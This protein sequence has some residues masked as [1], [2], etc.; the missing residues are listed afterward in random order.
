MTLS[1]GT[2]LGPYEVLSTV[3]AGGMGEVYKARDTR[4]ERTVAVKVLPDH[5]SSSP[6]VRQRFEREA[7]TISQLSHPHICALYDVGREGETEYL[8][9]EYLEGETLAERL[10]KGPLPLEQTLRYGVEIADALDKAHRR[11]IVH[12]DLKPGNV[13]LTKS[14]VKLLDFGLAKAVAPLPPQ[15]ELTSMPT[16]SRG[17][18]TQEG[19]ILGTVQYMAPEQ[20]EGQEADARTDIFALGCLLYEA[21]A[22]KRAFEGK[23]QV[24]LIGAILKDQP[25]PISSVQPMSPPALDRVVQACL[26]KDPE[27]RWQTAHDV[28]LQLK[29]VAEG[30]SVAGTPAPVTARR[31]VRERS[32][33]ILA[34]IFLAVALLLA[35]VHFREVP[36]EVRAA[37]FIVSPPDQTTLGTGP[38]APQAALSPDGRYL[39]LAL[40][41]PDAK[42]NLW[43]RPLDSLDVQRLAG[44]EEASLPFWSPD[45]RFI[46]F[47]TDNKLKTISISGGSPQTLA[48][49]SRPGGA[50][51]SRDGLILFAATRTS[52]I[53]RVSASGGIVTDLVT[54]ARHRE[55]AFYAFPQFLPDGRHFLYF[56]LSQK[57]DARGIYVTSLDS[58]ESKQI[59]NADVRAIYAHPGFLLFLRQGTLLAQRFDA[60]R[61]RLTGESVRIAE[62]VAYN[63]INGRN[64]VTVSDTGVLAYRAG[65]GAGIPTTELLW[66]DREGKRVGVAGGRDLYLRPGLSRDGRRIVV[67]RIDLRSD[68]RDLWVIDEARSTSSRLTFG[69]SRHSNAVWSPDGTRIVFASDLG[70]RICEKAAS[71]A[72]PERVLLS[73]DLPKNPTDWSADGRFILYDEIAAKTGTDIWILPLAGDQKPVPLLRTEFFEGQGQLSSDGRW[74]AYVSDESGRKEIYVQPFPFSGAKWQISSEGGSFP[75]WRGDGKELFYLSPDQKVMTVEVE[76]ESTLRAGKPRALFPARYFNIP[77]SP[78]TVSRDGQRFLIS[79]PPGEEGNTAPVTVIL[80]WTAELNKK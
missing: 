47:F 62:E 52:G 44:T 45:S 50:T 18:L 19:T 27:D 65:G 56:V 34:A 77:V 4:L 60:D 29:W 38:A 35:I 54:P 80:N 9:M 6:E 55:E 48:D 63:P 71:G 79:T 75:K 36:P 30:G 25:L 72:G 8:V 68:N 37:R 5:L 33:W 57:R 32:G 21:A 14:G 15:R 28:M 61:L 69:G 58:K 22:G 7:K 31:K 59:L 42:R 40:L 43:L 1:A 20:L 3:G 11:G 73:S 67:E 26:A 23:T 74:L 76:P 70:Y 24:S 53:G 66:F 64:T 16:V 78:Y 49:I 46:G 10:V 2:R 51:W 17:P 41:S 13:M 12:R 39:A